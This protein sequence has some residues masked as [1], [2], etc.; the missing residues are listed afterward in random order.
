MKHVKKMHCIAFAVTMIVASSWTVARAQGDI[1]VFFPDISQP[2]CGTFQVPVL[3]DPQGVPCLDDFGQGIFSLDMTVDY[4]PALLQ[5]MGVSV[6]GLI[7]EGWGEMKYWIHED[8]AQIKISIAATDPLQWCDTSPNQ[9]DA[10]PIVMIEYFVLATALFPACGDLSIDFVRFNE[11]DPSAFWT[12]GQFCVD[13]VPDS[14]GDNIVDPCDNCPDHHNPDQADGDQDGVGDVCDNCPDDPN[15]D[16]EDGDDDGVGAVCDCD[17]NDPANFPGNQEVCDGQDNDCDNRVDCVDPDVPDGDNDGVC[18][19]DDCDD[20]DPNNFPGNQE[21]CDGQDN[22]CDNLVDCGD[23]DVPDGDNDGVCACDD[24]DDNDPN[25]FPG[26]QEVCD[27]QD[28]DCDNR[29]DCVDPDVPD[30]D[31]DGVCECDDCDDNDPNN[32]PGNTEVIDGQDNDCDNLVDCADPDV[33]DGTPCDDGNP[34]TENDICTKGLCQGTPKVCDDGDACNGLE[35][36][37]PA[38]GDCAPGIPLEC[39]DGD[40]CNGLET[41]DPATGCV[42]GTPVECDDGDACNG[43]ETCDPATG[44]CMPGTP[45]D[46]DDNNPCTEDFCDP[47]T[48][49]CSNVPITG[50]DFSLTVVPAVARAQW[51]MGLM[52]TAQY[53]ITLGSI[54]CY[55]GSV[56]L[57]LAGFGFPGARGYYY[58][59]TGVVAVPPLGVATTKLT[60][61]VTRQAQVGNYVLTITG[62][63]GV[64]THSETVILEVRRPPRFKIIGPVPEEYVLA[65]NYPNPF[66]PETSIEFGLP[67]EGEVRVTVYNTLGHVV[68]VL[69]DEELEA[70]YYSVIWDATGL[71]TGVYFYRVEASAFRETRRMVYMK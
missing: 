43:L 16:Q 61:E 35:W 57:S 30:G 40:A 8:R 21:V 18:A 47:V 33:P 68:E 3:I 28:N 29:V 42:P 52:A 44:I 32:F 50:G 4:D 24:C 27:G 10:I 39:D 23:P 58:D 54:D 70:G 51:F 31:N 26:N 9:D 2:P 22:D 46:C 66:N 41:C 63:D 19:C 34:C 71:P 60:V 56:T 5:P 11:G 55:S 7:T 48:G 1:H 15:P 13:L 17:D 53:E 69:V 45:V 49:D 38:T 65:Q 14:D 25:N 20:N 12:W 62:G 64:K 6:A 67:Q 37:D 59:P 36:C